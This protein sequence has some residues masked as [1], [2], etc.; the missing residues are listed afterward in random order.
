MTSDDLPY[1][2][3]PVL[4]SKLRTGGITHVIKSH[5]HEFPAPPDTAL[6]GLCTHLAPLWT[7]ALD[8]WRMERID[9]L[10]VAD[11]ATT[12]KI[13]DLDFVEV[14]RT[15]TSRAAT[16]LA[17]AQVLTLSRS[18]VASLPDLSRE[19]AFSTLTTERLPWEI[20]WI[21]VNAR[22]IECPVLVRVRTRFGIES[23]GHFVGALC[24]QLEDGIE[25]APFFALDAGEL[26]CPIVARFKTSF[27]GE[28][29]SLGLAVCARE[30][31]GE[32]GWRA[33]TASGHDVAPAEEMTAAG[34]GSVAAALMVLSAVNVDLGPRELVGKRQKKW[35]R[36]RHP[37]P[38]VVKVRSRVGG[39]GETGGGAAAGELVGSHMVRGH[40]MHFTKGPIFDAHPEARRHIAGL[41]RE[42]VRIWRGGHVRGPKEGPLVPTVVNLR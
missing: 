38:H 25:V 37:L 30:E 2:I 29:E 27:A 40:W 14:A 22:P 24:R 19:E 8:C 3:P 31:D 16:L 41:D 15:A 32:L 7:Q 11:G 33:F 23:D 36:D 34:A 10:V 35:N 4:R 18:Q 13:K 6:S 39:R 28:E 5:G 26:C 9:P 12:P 42:A 21:E 17:E 20:T 1:V